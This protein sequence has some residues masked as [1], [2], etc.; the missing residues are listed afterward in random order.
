M[1]QI[2]III[3]QRYPGSGKLQSIKALYDNCTNKKNHNTLADDQTFSI[4]KN[5]LKNFIKTRGN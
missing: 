4:E 3:S 1:A 5:E 2:K